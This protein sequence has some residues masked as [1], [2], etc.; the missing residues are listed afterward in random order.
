MVESPDEDW[1]VQWR[2]LLASRGVNRLIP[3]RVSR[4]VGPALVRLPSGYQVVVPEAV[5]ERLTPK[6]RRLILCHE[7][8]HYEQRDLWRLLAV[9]VLALPHWFNPVSWWA[10]RKFEECTEWLCD[11]AA[12][13][14]SPCGASAIEY[15]RALM[16]LGSSPFQQPAW[17]GAA[18]G[19]R[20][21][22]R[23]QRLLSNPFKEDSKMK[24]IALLSIVLGL[25]MAGSVRIHLVA[26]E[27]SATAVTPGQK[28]AAEKEP[29][30]DENQAQKP[31][32]SRSAKAAEKP[33][34][35]LADLSE[36]PDEPAAHALFNRLIETLQKAESLSYRCLATCVTKEEQPE[37][38]DRYR[39]WLK[40]PNYCRIE[41]GN[42]V[43]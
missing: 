1:A 10:V 15:A 22:H 37:G 25:L 4:D 18:Q 40:K 27:P 17:V 24:K 26:K 42:T 3:F 19:S 13:N 35:T 41:V 30:A 9:R 38:M 29:Q 23:V 11:C 14:E 6:Q 16:Q 32:E 8:A 31:A 43:P 39:V 34:R 7:L 21:F 28:P 2:Q 33:T 20:L 5:W 12:A 36:F